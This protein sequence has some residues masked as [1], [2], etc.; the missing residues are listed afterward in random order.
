[1]SARGRS[2]RFCSGACRQKAYRS[3]SKEQLPA[4]MRQ[5]D[6]WTVADGKR[7]VTVSGT[8]ASSTRPET[9]ATHAEV[10]DQPHG[11]MLGG[12]LACIDLDHCINRRG[13]L[14]PWAREILNSVPGAVVER[15]VSKSGLHIFGL[16]PEAPGRKQGRVETYSR[17]RFIRT[18]ED[19]Y[20]QG[21]LVD[22]GPAVKKIASLVK[23]GSIPQR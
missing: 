8:A 3:R 17:E 15:S 22:L 20:R 1:M 2:P 9:W 18:T 16:L 11:V 21:S 5:L 6:R 14:A 12:G 7:P 23:G 19:I 4:R 10:K 13:H